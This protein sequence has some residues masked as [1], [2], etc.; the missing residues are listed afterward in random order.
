MQNSVLFNISKVIQAN[1]VIIHV[2]YRM[3]K[4]IEAL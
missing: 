1:L 3:V 2:I 4:I